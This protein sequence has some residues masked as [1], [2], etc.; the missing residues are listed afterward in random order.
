MNSE[1]DIDRALDGVLRELRQRKAPKFD[2]DDQLAAIRARLAE[3]PTEHVLRPVR[4]L[5]SGRWLAAAGL[6]AAGIL[7]WRTWMSGDSRVGELPRDPT[8]QVA[9]Q[10][11][12]SGEVR[13]PKPRTS[14]AAM[15]SLEERL[16]ES[17]GE[18][19]SLDKTTGSRL[20]AVRKS[21]LANLEARPEELERLFEELLTSSDPGRA[22]LGIAGASALGSMESVA[23]LS[24][25]SHR[26]DLAEESL[27]ALIGLGSLGRRELA[28]ALEDERLRAALKA[29]RASEDPAAL[30]ALDD[31]LSR[32]DWNA[33]PARAEAIVGTLLTFGADSVRVLTRSRR[34]RG[35]GWT[36]MVGRA[37]AS[38]DSPKAVPALRELLDSEELR[39]QAATALARLGSLAAMTEL[40]ERY[41]RSSERD[42]APALDRACASH[43]A[44]W[45]TLAEELDTREA[46]ELLELLIVFGYP[47]SAKARLELA[48][49]EDLPADARMLALESL[50]SGPDG[51]LAEA[52][53]RV[54][55]LSR[56]ERRL[57]AS[58]VVQASVRFGTEPVLDALGASGSSRARL[59]QLLVEAGERSPSGLVRISREL[60]TVVRFGSL[61]IVFQP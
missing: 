5:H 6:V 23:L 35:S 15:P 60:A 21:A 56:S 46:S 26:E 24:T 30:H 18:T 13:E 28:Q 54:P 22:K 19:A 9:G 57:A 45:S 2:V 41:V 40:T 43:A 48:Y 16:T 27:E 12:A 7:G 34:H 59:E 29:W 14:R 37:I 4:R 32:V 11:S 36:A 42:L 55:T 52:L 10:N 8:P 49:R 50:S 38:L 3:E 39:L 17:F 33:E 1:E 31:G 44:T 53:R 25:A 58:A 20:L 51:P 47:A 61:A